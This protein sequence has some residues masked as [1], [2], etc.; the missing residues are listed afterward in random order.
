MYPG[1]SIVVLTWLLGIVLLVTGLV[2]LFQ[3]LATLRAGR[4]HVAQSTDI[5]PGPAA[6]LPS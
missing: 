5:R 1:A 4:R 3:G 6:S 2:V